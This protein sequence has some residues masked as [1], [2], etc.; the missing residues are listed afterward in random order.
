[1]LFVHLRHSRKHHFVPSMERMKARK[2]VI[3]FDFPEY[4]TP[5]KWKFRRP[6]RS[7]VFLMRLPP[8]YA[9]GITEDSQL[10]ALAFSQS[11]S[12]ASMPGG[13]W[14]QPVSNLAKKDGPL[15]FLKRSHPAVFFVPESFIFNPINNLHSVSA[16]KLD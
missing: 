1:M 6:T 3:A 14:V 8:V 10:M 2:S 15:R 7:K 12:S 11:I 5:N 4:R 13:L 9:D 16:A